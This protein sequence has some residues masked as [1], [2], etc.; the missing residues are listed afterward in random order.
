MRSIDKNLFQ[1]RLLRKPCSSGGKFSGRNDGHIDAAGT[2]LLTQ[3]SG[4]T[5]DSSLGR[6]LGAADWR[7]DAGQSC[8]AKVKI[9][10]IVETLGRTDPLPY[11]MTGK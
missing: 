3:T 10:L 9:R 8:R 5:L 6:T 1:H 4:Q 7:R 11:P 2:Q